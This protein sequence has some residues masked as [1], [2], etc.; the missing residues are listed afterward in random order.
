[1]RLLRLCLIVGRRCR[2]GPNFASSGSAPAP[3]GAY[4]RAASSADPTDWP[5]NCL[6][7]RGAPPRNWPVLSSTVAVLRKG[8]GI[9]GMPLAE[10][11][12]TTACV[13][14]SLDAPDWAATPRNHSDPAAETANSMSKSSS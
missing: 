8:D 4:C 5:R 6:L 14:S 7:A 2:A 12:Q 13:S 10:G 9:L 11:A 1:M 3:E